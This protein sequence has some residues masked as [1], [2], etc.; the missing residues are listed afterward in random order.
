MVVSR[1]CLGS[2][3]MTITVDVGG[4]VTVTVT[5]TV[6]VGGPVTL[7]MIVDCLG[8][9]AVVIGVARGAMVFRCGQG[10]S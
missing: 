4:P 5:I 8:L 7:T 1:D 2:V 9:I 3:T 6:E 10:P